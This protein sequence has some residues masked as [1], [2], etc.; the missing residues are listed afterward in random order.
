MLINYGS[1]MY[2]AYLFIVIFVCSILYLIACKES[3][4]VKKIVVLFVAL[5]NVVQHLFKGK[6]YPHYN[7][8]SAFYLSTAYNVCAFLILISPFI[9]LFGNELLK[10]FLTFIGS[11]AG[12]IAMLVPYWYIGTSAFT[13]DVYRFYIC[14][15]LLFISSFLPW[16]LGLRTLK[17][18]HCWK[19][20]LLFFG[21]LLLILLNDAILIKTGNYPDT[22]PDDLLGSLI[23][24]NPGW[25]MGPSPS[26]AWIEEIVAIFSPSFFLG[27]NPWQ[28]HLPILW[29]AIPLYLGGT[30]LVYT[31]YGISKIFEKRRLK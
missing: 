12:M 4:C 3:T 8:S 10:N 22:N 31:L 14:H 11:F 1:F 24:V 29:Y 16:L 26:M 25:S 23:K 20:C 7:G 2:F 19:I 18:R 27:N 15:G 28:I 17:I 5:L 30:A 21:V 9:I 13:W 6:I